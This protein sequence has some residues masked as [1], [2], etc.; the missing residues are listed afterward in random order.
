MEHA[1]IERKAEDA[2]LMLATEDSDDDYEN[3]DEEYAYHVLHDAMSGLW[4]GEN[5]RKLDEFGI[6]NE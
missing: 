5:R 6:K 2:I 1:D 3:D 4:R